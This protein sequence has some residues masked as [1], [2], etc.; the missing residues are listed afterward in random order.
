MRIIW[1]DYQAFAFHAGCL[2]TKHEMCIIQF[3]AAEVGEKILEGVKN[4]L[5]LPD[6]LAFRLKN[7]SL[8]GR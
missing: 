7:V 4:G 1:V 6:C 2:L 8:Q 5:S 3:E